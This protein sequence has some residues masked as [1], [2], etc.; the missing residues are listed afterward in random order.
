MKQRRESR[1]GCKKT[2]EANQC[3]VR[4]TG[5][6]AVA[7]WS[8]GDGRCGSVRGVEEGAFCLAAS[9]TTAASR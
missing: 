2:V 8:D 6:H 9:T 3:R 4:T 1:D 5:K 7:T